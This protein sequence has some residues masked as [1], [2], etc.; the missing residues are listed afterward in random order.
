[1]PDSGLDLNLSLLSSFAALLSSLAILIWWIIRKKRNRIWLPTLRLIKDESSPLPKIKLQKPPLLP[2]LCF[3][4]AAICIVFLSLEPNE[5][6][7]R[8]L[9]SKVNQI[10]I[11]LDASPTTES[12]RR[13]S[14]WKPFLT[15]LFE[16]Y[17]QSGSISVSSS[18]SSK[19]QQPTDSNDFVQWVDSQG[20]HREGLK[21]GSNI[22]SHLE[23]V[24]SIDK[25]IIISDFDKYSWS[26][27]NWQYL[28]S[29]MEVIH[30]APNRDLNSKNI[31]VDSAHI[32]AN[33]S[34][35]QVVWDVKVYRNYTGISSE[36][37]LTAKFSDRIL[38][39][40]SW[41]IHSQ[42]KFVRVQIQWPWSKWG[43]IL[44]GSEEIVWSIETQSPNYLTADD[45]FRTLAQGIQKDILMISE[46]KGEMFLEDSIHHLKVTL[47]VMGFNVKRIDTAQIQ[48]SFWDLPLWA[49]AAGTG[50]LKDFCPLNYENRRL[51]LQKPGSLKRNAP[52]PL[53]WLFPKDLNASYQNL[54]WCYSRLM[55]SR[56]ASN[57][58]PLYCEDV[59]TREQYISVLQ[60]LGAKQIGG[61][62]E[63]NSGAIAWHRK[64]DHSELFAFTVP[65]KPS[66]ITGISYD[67]LPSIVQSFLKLSYLIDEQ[68]NTR[69]SAW[70]RSFNIS[71][72]I[73]DLRISNVPRGESLYVYE[74]STALP[75]FWD[76]AS[77][78]ISRSPSGTRE[79][80]DPR[81][82]LEIIFWCLVFCFILEGT[83]ILAQFFKK[84][85]S[86]AVII[87]LLTPPFTSEVEATIRLNLIGYNYSNSN[88][89]SLARDV[90][91]RTSI[92]LH[93]E[94]NIYN[95]FNRDTL[96]EPWFWVKNADVFKS[97]SEIS[98]ED[99]RRYVRRG[100]F[101]VVENLRDPTSLGEIFNM[102]G[103]QW[104]VIP[105][106]HEI[107]RSFHLLDSLPKCDELVWLGYNFDQRIAAIGVPYGFLDSILDVTRQDSCATKVT[108]ER[109]TR[110]F[111]NILMVALATDYKKDQIHLP[112]ILKRLR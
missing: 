44:N 78:E 62:T 32:K 110:I 111:I 16:T 108:R 86:R 8:S 63:D 75:P 60:S 77:S 80:K 98:S 22:P 99:I 51:A 9:G 65:L 15:N 102:P 85:F 12:M 4:G 93:R 26:D 28:E 50:P 43:D 68:S 95:R 5:I 103:G 21:I 6:Q 106:D 74:S 84:H 1:M 101:I 109:A 35:R 88:I 2:F 67:Q 97:N 31:F 64:I 89:E 29:K 90:S 30:A 36:G 82:W 71:P 73:K 45:E 70:P 27:F 105:P 79:E 59:E 72:Q 53:L 52:L 18:N 37:I 46:P 39:Q 40:S 10:H 17:S 23:S 91:G 33:E 13:D 48:K 57:N 47:D 92:T 66:R 56:K 19:I 3:V 69:K 58:M 42:D 104:K 55:E 20:I 100:G 61:S 41:N 76:M 107:M 83:W 94:T 87:L 25:L 34:G 54:C 14:Q 49:I 7:Y 11:Y 112:E 24:G 81:L 96:K 38:A